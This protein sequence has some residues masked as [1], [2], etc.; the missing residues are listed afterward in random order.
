MMTIVVGADGGDYCTL[1]CS[2]AMNGSA[3]ACAHEDN[4]SDAANGRDTAR[5]ICKDCGYD[6]VEAVEKVTP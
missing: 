3:D 4:I 2:I 5:L 1:R 6:R